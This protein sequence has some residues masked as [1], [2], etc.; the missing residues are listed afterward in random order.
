MYALAKA[1]HFSSLAGFK[2]GEVMMI[3]EVSSAITPV[4]TRSKMAF[5]EGFAGDYST[6]INPGETDLDSRVSVF[7]RIK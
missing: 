6:P 1:T 2:L 5:A 4:M 7:F 3:S